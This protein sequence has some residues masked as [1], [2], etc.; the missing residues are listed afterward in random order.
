MWLVLVSF[1]GEVWGRLHGLT[2]S[3]WVWLLFP[4]HPVRQTVSYSL[5]VRGALGCF[6]QES[7]LVQGV[8]YVGLRLPRQADGLWE[9]VLEDSSG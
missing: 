5:K 3:W 4:G 8:G 9:A 1:S 6:V 2:V 7:R